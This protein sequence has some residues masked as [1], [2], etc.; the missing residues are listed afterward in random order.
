MPVTYQFIKSCQ[1]DE[2]VICLG[3]VL[4]PERVLG[5]GIRVEVE[6]DTGTILENTAFTLHGIHDACCGGMILSSASANSF[7]YLSCVSASC[8]RTFNCLDFFCPFLSGI[9][10]TIY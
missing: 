5:K 7:S 4:C 2:S 8:S 3:V 10:E 6:G 9:L 1:K